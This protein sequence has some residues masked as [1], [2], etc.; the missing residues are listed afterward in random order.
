MAVRLRM[1]GMV[2]VVAWSANTALGGGMPTCTG[3]EDTIRYPDITCDGGDHRHLNTLRP[4]SD[5]IPAR[6]KACCCTCDSARIPFSERMEAWC[7]RTID[8]DEPTPGDQPNR[9]TDIMRRYCADGRISDRS[10]NESWPFQAYQ[11][12]ADM[13]GPIPIS[14]QQLCMGDHVD[15]G[16][17]REYECTYIARRQREALSCPYTQC[18]MPPPEPEPEPEPD[19]EP[20]PE[21]EPDSSWSV[22]LQPECP[23]DAPRMCSGNCDTGLD[24]VHA[25]SGYGCELYFPFPSVALPNIT[26]IRATD[27][28]GRLN[29]SLCCRDPCADVVCPAGERRSKHLDFEDSELVP[30][31]EHDFI[32][33]EYKEAYST[34]D[35]CT[36]R[37]EVEYVEPEVVYCTGNKDPRYPDVVCDGRQHG[38]NHLRPNSDEIP[39]RSPYCCCYCDGKADVLLSPERRD[40][41]DRDDHLCNAPFAYCVSNDDAGNFVNDRQFVPDFVEAFEVSAPFQRAIHAENKCTKAMRRVRCED[42]E[43]PEECEESGPFPTFTE[44]ADASEGQDICLQG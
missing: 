2:A 9:C 37:P 6:S 32:S 1:L 33:E 23:T 4:N 21:P 30:S 40:L 42:G 22:D 39:G 28:A 43:D 11:E 17:E 14:A 26:D 8:D 5:A 12:L 31:W 24:V 38:L 15:D 34:I 13:T 29:Q 16:S 41:C 36:N 3:N 18:T 10:C 44:R 25:E 35:C 20:E 27:D 19:P 7:V